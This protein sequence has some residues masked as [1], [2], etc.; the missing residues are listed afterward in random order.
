LENWFMF[1][2]IQS[3]CF[4]DKN[5]LFLNMFSNSSSALVI[6]HPAFCFFF[7]DSNI[8]RRPNIENASAHVANL[9]LAINY[10]AP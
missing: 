6:Q 7:H 3:L 1:L 9:I 2:K 5:N 10:D 8:H 4:V